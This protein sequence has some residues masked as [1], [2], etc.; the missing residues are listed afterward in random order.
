[1]RERYNLFPKL[2]ALIFVL[3][4]IIWMSGCS[5]T[6][7]SNP[8]M[9]VDPGFLLKTTNGRLFYMVAMGKGIDKAEK[10]KWFQRKLF[11][12]V[13]GT[14]PIVYKKFDFV[15][16]YQ[17]DQSGS[18]EDFYEFYQL[19]ADSNWVGVT[20]R[21]KGS[22]LFNLFTSTKLSMPNVLY[23]PRLLVGGSEYTHPVSFQVNA[24]FTIW[25]LEFFNVVTST[26]GRKDCNINVNISS[27]RFPK[28]A[29]LYRVKKLMYAGLED[30]KWYIG[31][32]QMLPQK[33]AYV[34]D[35][36]FTSVTIDFLP[37]K[38]FYSNGFYM[39]VSQDLLYYTDLKH[40]RG[41]FELGD[42]NKLENQKLDI[43][44]IIATEKGLWVIGDKDN[45]CMQ[46]VS[47]VSWNGNKAEISVKT[48][49]WISGF[50][51]YGMVMYD[52]GFLYLGCENV[53]ADSIYNVGVYNPSV[54]YVSLSPNRNLVKLQ[55]DTK[56]NK[57]LLFPVITDKILKK[58]VDEF[59]E[60]IR[61]ND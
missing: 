58:Y 23:S 15:G 10:G 21:E 5:S 61:N 30:G 40:H 9:V 11:F 8:P 49:P 59:I 17:L 55:Y 7:C 2:R 25:D 26:I 60:E 47:F 53:G 45:C 57:I 42:I 28:F 18:W 33:G 37:D 29:L 27:E 34:F 13:S 36:P 51:T 14:E 31:D 39:F 19:A 43:Y 48:S 54:R 38:V 32:F 56:E 35:D 3:I 52:D 20:V 4:G 44:T 24:G 6:C 41:Y 16:K 50:L 46:K 1:M 22:Y 12:D